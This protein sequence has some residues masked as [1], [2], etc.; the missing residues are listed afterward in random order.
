MKRMVIGL[1]LMLLTAVPA[2]ATPILWSPASVSDDNGGL[3]L[4]GATVSIV[5]GNTFTLDLPSYSTTSQFGFPPDEVD[6]AVTAT[7][8]GQEQIVGLRYIFLGLFTGLGSADFL[9]SANSAFSSGSF[10]TSQRV[11]LLTFPAA[12][13][14]NLGALLN[15]DDGGD[16]AAVRRIQFEVISTVPE[17][18][19]RVLLSSGLVILAWRSR[20]RCGNESRG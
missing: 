13:S 3:F 19:G 9:V 16:F 7:A 10:S 11:G 15:L 1:S 14:V 5:A 4:S 20:A 6:L 8:F 18:S 17:P 12:T 2:S